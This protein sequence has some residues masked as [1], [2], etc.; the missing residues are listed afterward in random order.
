M[1]L[2][3]KKAKLKR[4]RGMTHDNFEND[5][6]ASSQQSD[7]IIYIYIY[8]ELHQLFALMSRLKVSV[9]KLSSKTTLIN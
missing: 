8:V 2:N 4:S 9:L 6:L 7:Q 3:M 5:L 1:N